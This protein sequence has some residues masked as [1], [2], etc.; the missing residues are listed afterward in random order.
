MN[1]PKG[2]WVVFLHLVPLSAPRR[3][4]NY[5]ICWSAYPIVKPPTPAAILW[6]F[7][8]LVKVRDHQ[9]FPTR[10]GQHNSVMAATDCAIRTLPGVDGPGVSW[11]ALG[12]AERDEAGATG[13]AQ[14]ER[15]RV[16]GGPCRGDRL[17]RG[18]GA[19]PVRAGRSFRARPPLRLRPRGRGRSLGAPHRSPAE[20]GPPTGRD[21]A[22]PALRSDRVDCAPV[23][24]RVRTVPSAPV[25]RTGLRG[26]RG[27][28]A[29]PRVRPP[30]GRPRPRKAVAET[31]PPVLA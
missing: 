23:A 15:R 1:G 30:V 12:H 28:T 8:R 31:F 10:T 29:E 3:V 22:P 24:G 26:R 17:A 9:P 20:A 21:P 11:Y 19:P 7:R 25:A 6:P 16:G 13:S 5:S 18:D 27:P 14:G 4:S 2:T